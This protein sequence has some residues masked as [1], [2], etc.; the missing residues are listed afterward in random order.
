MKRP[1]N[2]NFLTSK[3]NECLELLLSAQDLFDEICSEYP[4]ASSDT[5]N[6]GHYMD[7]ARNAILMRG[8]RRIDTENLLI[9]H[10]PDPVRATLRS[11]SVN[12]PDPDDL[13]P[14]FSPEISEVIDG[15]K[16]IDGTSLGENMTIPS[17]AHETIKTDNISMNYVATAVTHTIPELLQNILTEI[18][19]FG[20][21]G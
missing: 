8:A 1:A 21:K 6:F 4:Q 7:A 18:Q 10:R 15:A 20:A 17:S 9:R 11:N 3:E 2:V 5:Y 12:N 19:K 13:V 16:L 14:D